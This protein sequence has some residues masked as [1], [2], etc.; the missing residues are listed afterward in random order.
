[1]S[2]S[3]TAHAAAVGPYGPLGPPDANGV[4]LPVGFTARVVGVTGQRVPGTA[5]NPDGTRLYFSSQRGTD[6]KTGMT[7]E[8]SVPF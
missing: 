2:R 5:F 4:R 7:F 3:R 1:M 8:V 6:G